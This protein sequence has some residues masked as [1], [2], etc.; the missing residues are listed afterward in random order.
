MQIR[1]WKDRGNGRAKGKAKSKV[2]NKELSNM[3]GNIK[4]FAGNYILCGRAGHWM[5]VCPQLATTLLT[6]P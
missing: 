4:P 1:K 6:P 5:T 3:K 2:E